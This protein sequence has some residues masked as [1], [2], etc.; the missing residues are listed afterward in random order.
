MSLNIFCTAIFFVIIPTVNIIILCEL[1]FK[2]LQPL[3]VRLRRETFPFLADITAC[4]RVT[5]IARMQF[6]NSEPDRDM[7]VPGDQFCLS[8]TQEQLPCIGTVDKKTQ[9]PQG[10][11][12]SEWV[13]Q[14]GCSHII[15]LQCWGNVAQ[16]TRMT[17][18]WIKTLLHWHNEH[19][20]ARELYYQCLS[21][22]L[23]RLDGASVQC[24]REGISDTV[25]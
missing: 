6:G 5:A 13:V 8:L 17:V 11:S 19:F 1:H 16:M 18:M 15:T 3:L 23:L 25:V 12:M 21:N 2:T 24:R 22:N 20:F 10:V 9:W 14:C 4:S 7:L